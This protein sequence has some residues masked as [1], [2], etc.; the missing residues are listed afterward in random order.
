MR[1]VRGCR[2]SRR[3]VTVT[4]AVIGLGFVATMMTTDVLG[5]GRE[6]STSSRPAEFRVRHEAADLDAMSVTKTIVANFPELTKEQLVADV[7][8]LSKKLEKCFKAT[9]LRRFEGLSVKAALKT[10]ENYAGEFRKVIPIE[11]FTHPK[12]HC[13]KMNYE[14]HSNNRHVWGHI[15]EIDFDE[16]VAKDYRSSLLKDVQNSFDNHFTSQ[17][18]CL[19]NMFLLG[20]PKCGSTFLWCLIEKLSNATTHV[21]PAAFKEPGWWYE[22]NDVLQEMDSSVFG[23]YFANFAT[24]TEA[25]DITGQTGLMIVDGTPGIAY[26]TPRYNEKHHH[27]TNYCLL[28]AA[29]PH[30]LPHAKFIM[31]MRE[32]SDALY[33][34]FWWACKGRLTDKVQTKIPSAFHKGVT[35]MIDTFLRC[36]KNENVPDIREA[37]APFSSDFRSCITHPKRLPLLDKCVHEMSVHIIERKGIPNCVKFGFDMYLYFIH[38]RRWLSITS[39]EKFLFLTL[40]DTNDPVTVATSVFRLMDIPVPPDIDQV[41]SQVHAECQRRKNPHKV[42]YSESSSS[43]MWNETRSLL[44]EFFAPFNKMLSDLL[45]DPKFLF[46]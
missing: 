38:V 11:N 21:R 35:T 12:Q 18:L 32:P 27:K 46:P 29:I 13:W 8:Q 37:C 20:F 36:M 15:G 16:I 9:D 43:Q 31:I 7:Q 14:I 24:P 28:P 17:T 30:F 1:S 3:S 25:V 5:S 40:N 2:F 6:D 26:A 44:K 42:N 39:R 34:L 10:A 22:R 41:A 45:D 19:P 4:L 33:S 23:R